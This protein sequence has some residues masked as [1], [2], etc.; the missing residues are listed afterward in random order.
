MSLCR[1]NKPGPIRSLPFDQMLVGTWSTQE[2][3][4]GVPDNAPAL[5]VIME[6]LAAS[7][8]AVPPVQVLNG[9]EVRYT[10]MFAELKIEEAQGLPGEPTLKQLTLG[11]HWDEQPI[12]PT[13]GQPGFFTYTFVSQ[14]Q[15]LLVRWR[16]TKR[17]RQ[18]CKAKSSSAP[19]CLSFSL[20]RRASCC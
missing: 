20:S 16:L 3:K 12:D 14:R 9:Q 11:I 1:A 8:A 17:D 6:E 19:C 13:N 10:N 4:G 15:S 18:L 7:V 5:Q 2:E